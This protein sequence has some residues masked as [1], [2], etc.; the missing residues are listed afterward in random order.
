MIEL[1]LP[2][3]PSANRYWRSFV[4]RGHTRPVVVPSQEAKEYKARVAGIAQ[5][6]GIT[7]P[8]IGRVEVDIR[9]YP[10]RPQDWAKR[11]RRDPICWD[12]DVQCLDLD[13]CRKVLYDSLK[14]VVIDDD[15][16]IWRDSAQRM[17]PDG[18]GRVVVRIQR[19]VLAATPQASL[20]DATA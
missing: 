14:G 12:D 13:N 17:E 15:R 8:L 5:L 16:W 11:A 3:P 1:V 9:L 7:Q 2:Y 19:I 4:P 20:L 18:D 6:A 10:H